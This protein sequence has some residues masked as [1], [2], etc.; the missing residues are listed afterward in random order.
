M[1]GSMKQARAFLNPVVAATLTFASL[2]IGPAVFPLPAQAQEA[3]VELLLDQLADPA[4][5][6][7]MR[8]ERQILNA[9]G[10]SGSASVDYLFQRGEAALQAGQAAEAIDHFSAVLDYAPDFAEAWNGRATAYFLANRIGQS[11]AD[12]EQVLRL[13]PRHFG[14]LAGLGIILEQLERHEEALEAYRA[15]LAIHPHQQQVIDSVQRLEL[16]SAGQSL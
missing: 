2:C 10:Q 14:A 5:D 8:I 7:W 12:I 13:N 4:Q 1:L 11:L 6:R 16:A 3:D 9:W 15:S